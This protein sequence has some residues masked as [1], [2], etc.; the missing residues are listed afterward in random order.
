MVDEKA[1]NEMNLKLIVKLKLNEN[2]IEQTI[3][4]TASEINFTSMKLVKKLKMENEIEET[5]NKI[6]PFGG[7]VVSNLGK[8]SLKKRNVVL[9]FIVVEKVSNRENLLIGCKTLFENNFSLLC[10]N[11]TCVVKLFNS[12][13]D[14]VKYKSDE[15]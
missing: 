6:L 15:K 11:G 1:R 4:D 3:L 10:V 7:N 8:I 9:K 12:T 14:I 13:M 5:K 2:K